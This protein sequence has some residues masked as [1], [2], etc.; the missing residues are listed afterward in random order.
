MFFTYGTADA[1]AVPKPHHLLRDL[2][3]DWFYLSGTGL[4]TVVLETRPLNGSSIVV[5]IALKCTVIELGAC[6]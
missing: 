4:A 1:T 2:N 3:P 5:T 6:M